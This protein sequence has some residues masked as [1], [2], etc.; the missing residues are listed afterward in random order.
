MDIPVNYLAVLVAGLSNMV[1]GYLWYGPLFGKMWMKLSGTKMSSGGKTS[2]T[3][4]YI[5]SYVGAVIIAYILAHFIYL[6]AKGMGVDIT[7]TSAITTAFWGWLGFIVPT[8]IASV[9]WE[10]KSWNLWFLGI[11][12]WLVSLI[13]MAAILVG[14]GGY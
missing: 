10:G 5:I 1:I 13:A 2:A 12:Y 14:M 3:G 9:L 7:T 8:S 4:G 6:N 11:A